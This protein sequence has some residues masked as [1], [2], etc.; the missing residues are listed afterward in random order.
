MMLPTNEEDLLRTTDHEPCPPP[1]VSTVLEPGSSP[2][3]AAT[4]DCVVG[5]ATEPMGSEPE[6]DMSSISVPGYEIE[7]VLGR[8]GMGVVYKARHLALKRTV[9][10]KMVLAGGHAGPRRTGALP[11]RG[12]GGGAV[13]ASEHRADPRGRRGGRPSLLR[14]EFVEGGNLAGKIAGKP[15]PAREAAKLVEA[16]ARAMQLAHS[17]NVVHRDLK[18]AN[19]LLTADGT[20]KITDFGLARQTG[21]RQRRDAGR[22]GDG[23]AVVH[24]PGAGVRAGPRGRTRGGHLRARRD[25]LRLPGRS[26]A[27]PGRTIVETLDQVRTQEPVP[28]SRWQRSVPLD[29]ETIC[30]KC[31]RKEP[32]KR[33]ASAAELADELVR[34]QQGEPI[35]ARPVGR[36]ERMWRWCKRNPWVAS[37]LGAVAASLSIGMAGTSYYAI[38]AGKREREAADERP[39][40]AGGKNAE[41]P[42]LVRRGNQPRQQR[43]G[44]RRD[45]LA[46]ATARRLRTTRARRA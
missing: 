25:P 15:M 33:Y 3:F 1:D 23:N 7:A 21:Q 19:I 43:L 20:P 18:P 12:R 28:P 17:R 45:C 9:A 26:A 36:A 42:T 5:E 38:Q 10:L 35:L 2:I 4:A 27:V 24:G 22:G 37:L 46:R 11:H 30:L 16:L 41:R 40:C 39:A 34:F 44:G 13:A 31:L 6:R 29:L 14:L 32:E 8:G